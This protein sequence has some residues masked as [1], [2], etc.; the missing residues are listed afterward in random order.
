[1]RA[2]A[3]SA[4]AG[5]LLAALTAAACSIDGGAPGE[6]Q[7]AGEVPDTVAVGVV[8]R[9]HRDGRL[10]LE[11]T[12]S[13]AE[14]WNETKKTILTDAR[15]VEFDQAGAQATAGEA[16]K[17]IFHSDT[18][19][20]DISG[21]VRVRSEVEEGNVTAEALSWDNKARRLSA[22]AQDVVTLRKDDGTSISG[23]GFLGDFRTRELTFSGPVVGT[24]VDSE[25]P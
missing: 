4:R 16:Q 14:T 21:G 12:A 7:A 15:F 11:L 23:S 22:P 6:G 17:V 18:E 5:L 8:H 10:S 20:A 2:A 1:M 25:T 9:I 13:R 3:L 19:N 24:Y